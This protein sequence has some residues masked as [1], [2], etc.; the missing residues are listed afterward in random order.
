[1]CAIVLCSLIQELGSLLALGHTQ[2]RTRIVGMGLD[3]LQRLVE[4]IHI[5]LVS[6]QCL[7]VVLYIILYGFLLIGG[8]GCLCHISDLDH[9]RHL[10]GGLSEHINCI[11]H[12]GDLFCCL[13]FQE[14][15]RVTIGLVVGHIGQGLVVC[16]YLSNTDQVRVNNAIL[17][18]IPHI[19]VSDCSTHQ[20]CGPIDLVCQHSRGVDQVIKLTCLCGT[21]R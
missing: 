12:Q 19:G 15:L 18:Y 10:D 17:S 1:M 14:G 20:L 4:V 2:I 9:S 3:V 11:V 6:G 5:P 21:Y 13:V 7:H 16:L 8:G